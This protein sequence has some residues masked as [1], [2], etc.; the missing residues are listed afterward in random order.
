MQHFEPCCQSTNQRLGREGLETLVINWRRSRFFRLL[1]AT[2]SD[3]PTLFLVAVIWPFSRLLCLFENASWRG[4]RD[5]PLLLIHD[6]HA[7][8]SSELDAAV[9]TLGLRVL[10]TPYSRTASKCVLRATD[11]DDEKGMLRLHDPAQ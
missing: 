3:R 5:L 4:T 6:R 2:Q 1:L 10:K 7:T 8:F 11:R 9:N